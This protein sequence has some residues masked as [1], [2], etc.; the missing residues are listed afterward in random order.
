VNGQDLDYVF[1][2]AV[3]AMAIQR[4]DVIAKATEMLKG[5]QPDHPF[6][7]QQRDS[8]LLA[9]LEMPMQSPG[10]S[11]S[12]AKGVIRSIVEPLQR[13]L[14]LKPN[15]MGVGIDVNNAL[16]DLLKPEDKN[17]KE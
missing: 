6:V 16:S 4:Q 14:M 12:T 5:I 11:T 17:R 10:K 3:I 8:L 1:T 2:F 15:F 9:I 7:R 13:Y